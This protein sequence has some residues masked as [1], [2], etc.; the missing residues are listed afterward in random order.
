[1]LLQVI[2]LAVV[3]GI[4]EFLP[5]SSSAHLLIVQKLI[6]FQKNVL[7]YDIFFHF[8][9]L[10]AVLLFFRREIISLADLRK[11]EARLE[12]L[13][14]AL[15]SVPAAVAG[16]GF[17]KNLEPLFSNIF[18]AAAG[19]LLTALLIFISRRLNFKLSG[20]WLTVLLIGLFQAIAII[21]G[22]SRSGATIAVALICGWSFLRAFR[23]SFLLS[24][25]AVGGAFLL[26]LKTG[27]S[28]SG[29]IFYLIIAVVIAFFSG[30]SALKILSKAGTGRLWQYFAYYC[31]FLGLLV[32][33]INLLFRIFFLVMF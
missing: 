19:L 28:L 16:I 25:P 13:Q 27:L 22:V 6:D 11:K 2:L 8:G 31:F 15:A 30:Y 3:Q 5:V 32:F 33:V 21:P 10:L 9:T 18:V 1:M 24:L 23:F 7:T 12:L 4:T 17:K 26:E 14:I 20:N 29:D